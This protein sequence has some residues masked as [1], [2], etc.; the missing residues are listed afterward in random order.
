MLSKLNNRDEV[1]IGITNPVRDDEL[2]DDDDVQ[3]VVGFAVDS[4]S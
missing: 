2:I 3:A 1:R 4:Y